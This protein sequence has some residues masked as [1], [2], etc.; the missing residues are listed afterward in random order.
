MSFLHNSYLKVKLLVLI[1]VGCN[2]MECLF[3]TKKTDRCSQQ[4]IQHCS[5]S[6]SLG[7]NQILQV[8]AL[9]NTTLYSIKFEHH[10]T[11]N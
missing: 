10:A 2:T 4:I 3:C 8:Q 6:S 5:I 9:S 1:D 11:S 7:S